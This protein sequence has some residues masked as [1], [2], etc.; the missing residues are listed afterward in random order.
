MIGG[1]YPKRSGVQA[2]SS[3]S[4]PHAVL[5]PMAQLGA[6]SGTPGIQGNPKIA[7]IGGSGSNQRN[8]NSN[9]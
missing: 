9:A 8:Y 4:G 6:I 1:A 3:I 2:L 7:L 5:G